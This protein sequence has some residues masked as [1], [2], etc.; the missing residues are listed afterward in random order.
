MK[1]TI[2]MTCCL[3]LIVLASVLLFTSCAPQ[4]GL[5]GRDAR[6]ISSSQFKDGKFFN[7]IETRVSTA[8][9]NRLGSLLEFFTDQQKREPEAVLPSIPV[10]VES[11]GATN[12]LRLTWLG[13]STCLIEMDGQVI[14]TDPTFSD[15]AS[16][17]TFLGP[18]R[19]GTALPLQLKDVPKVDIVLISHDHYDHLDYRSIKALIDKTS[20]FCVPLGVG[21]HLEYWGVPRN[22]IVEMDW[23]QEQSNKGI[24]LVATPARHFSGRWLVRDKTL[25]S[26]WVI[27]G[28]KHRIFFGGDSGY[29]DG[30]RSIGDKYGPFDLTLLESGAYNEAWSEI[31]MMPEETVQAHID[32]KGKVLLPIHWGQFN[33]SLHNW[34]EPIER[35]LAEAN[36]RDVSVATPLMGQPV[37]DPLGIPYAAWWHIPKDKIAKTGDSESPPM[38]R[39]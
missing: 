8:S 4:L 18:K 28:Q 7:T 21:G 29:F 11:I 25:W 24:K 17:F 14:L 16:P 27:Q 15:R 9:G 2:Q 34:T 30:F 33:L 20:L 36:R 10:A 23:W 39:L 32:L 26:S 35:L 12:G 5:A 38:Q 37:E 13:H 31:H 22:K 6:L 19:F 1:R 3:V